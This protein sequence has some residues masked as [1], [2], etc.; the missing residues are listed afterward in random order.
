MTNKKRTHF[1]AGASFCRGL[2]YISLYGLNK[3]NGVEQKNTAIPVMTAVCKSWYLSFLLG[4]VLRG[5]IPLYFILSF[6][7]D[8]PTGICSFPLS[9][10]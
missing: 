2:P 1:T 8:K 4:G 7:G 6:W 3:Q 9:V 5:S 10:L